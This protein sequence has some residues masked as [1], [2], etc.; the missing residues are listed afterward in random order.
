M[1]RALAVR[2]RF[3]YKDLS[4][5]VSPISSNMQ[6]IIYRW[7]SLLFQ[8]RCLLKFTT[9]RL[10]TK[11]TWGL[12]DCVTVWPV[13]NGSIHIYRVMW[14]HW[15]LLM[16]LVSQLKR[17]P[18]E[19]RLLSCWMEMHGWISGRQH[20]IVFAFCPTLFFSARRITP[21]WNFLL[22][23]ILRNYYW[24]HNTFLFI[25]FKQFVWLL[26]L[27]TNDKRCIVYAP[28]NLRSL[29]PFRPNESRTEQW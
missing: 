27:V 8:A 29:C 12:M 4:T 25:F 16:Q 14:H 19:H 28:Q 20:D 18:E 24:M 17:L 5:S 21:K 3:N 13:F 6:F 23:C 11:N 7:K 26:C 9:V 22:S 2:N 10:A 1:L 15:L